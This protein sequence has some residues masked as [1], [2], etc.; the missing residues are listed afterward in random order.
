MGRGVNIATII[1]ILV[2]MAQCGRVDPE[3]Q[4]SESVLDYLS[5]SDAYMYIKVLP[6]LYICK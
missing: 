1:I 4:L 6:C 2:T 3:P 5:S